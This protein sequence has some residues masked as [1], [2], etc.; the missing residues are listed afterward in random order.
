M[1]PPPMGPNQMNYPPGGAGSGKMPP[2]GAGTGG[3]PHQMSHFS[4]YNS[5][6]PQQG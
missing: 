3:A 5:Q 2:G 1:M 6:Y 4:Q